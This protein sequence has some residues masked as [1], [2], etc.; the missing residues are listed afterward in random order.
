MGRGRPLR[1]RFE[2]DCPGR[3]RDEDLD[4]HFPLSRGEACDAPMPAAL[5]GPAPI[6]F[7]RQRYRT[8]IVL[9]R[10]A[11]DLASFPVLEN[12]AREAVQECSGRSAEQAALTSL[13]TC[14]VSSPVA[15][16]GMVI[17]FRCF[18]EIL[19]F[20]KWARLGTAG[21]FE[22]INDC[23]ILEQALQPN[24]RTNADRLWFSRFRPWQST[25]CRP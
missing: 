16:R 3:A 24:H 20:P 8:D 15:S 18:A 12:A 21:P 9:R 5:L 1:R 19:S 13:S 22:Y 10:S 7:G 2:N 14:P 25:Q 4:H 23:C 6:R 17:E 11:E